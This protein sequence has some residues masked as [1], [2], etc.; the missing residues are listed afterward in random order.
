MRK[1][2]NGGWRKPMFPRVPAGLDTERLHALVTAALAD[3][4][5]TKPAWVAGLRDRVINNGLPARVPQTVVFAAQRAID[6]V[7]ALELDALKVPSQAKSPSGPQ[8][9]LRTRLKSLLELNDDHESH[10]STWS[11]TLTQILSLIGTVVPV[12]S[13]AS[14]PMFTVPL[15]DLVHNQTELVGSIVARLLSHATAP[16]GCRFGSVL[17]ERVKANL[18]RVSGLTED[19]ARANPLRLKTPAQSGLRGH[20]LLAA[21]LNGTPFLKLLETHVPFSIPPSVY[22]EH[23]FGAAPSG[24]GK[25]QLL[26]TL[27]SVWLAQ[28]DPPSLF[29]IDDQ[30]DARGVLQNIQRLDLFHPEHGRL[31]DRLLIFSPED[32]PALNFFS[33][34]SDSPDVLE[35]FLYLF[36][37]L[38]ASLSTHQS[39]AVTYILRLMRKIPNASIETLRSVMTETPRSWH[40]SKYAKE[41]ATLDPIARSYFETQFYGPGLKITKEAVSRRLYALMANPL[42]VKMFSA[43]TS[44]FD[45]FACMQ[46]KKI[47][48]INASRPKLGEDASKVYARFFISQILAA[49][50]KRG[51]LAEDQRPLSILAIDECGP[52]YDSQAERLL[53]TARKYSVAFFSFT[54]FIEIIPPLVKAALYA[55]TSTKVV[56]PVSHDDAAKLAREMD[57]SVDFIRSMSKHATTTEFCGMIRNHSP[58]VRISVPLGVL[59]AQPRMDAA[60]HARLRQANR[61]LVTAP[62]TVEPAST[63]SPSPIQQRTTDIE[64]PIAPKKW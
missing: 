60:A 53:S 28:N 10:A 47:V 51:E 36:S 33:S 50:Y 61:V 1:P 13:G 32:E 12:D 44:S 21:Y 25:T 23:F 29:I 38:D 37:A 55:N 6:E 7:V 39:T 18:L 17:A 48:L 52:H 11:A 64:P 58:A 3:A 31:R 9:S 24:H 46:T 34:I 54:Q 19:A 62:T 15:I 2:N 27:V 20:E 16:G 59:E 41:I 63:S 56:G 45:P 30:D 42:F 8:T 43:P 40:Q 35:C 5:W 4:P 22:T 14:P 26:Q 57:T 49:C